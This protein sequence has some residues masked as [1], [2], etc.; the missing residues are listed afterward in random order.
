MLPADDR[1]KTKWAST[2]SPFLVLSAIFLPI[3]LQKVG[4]EGK[5]TYLGN[6]THYNLEHVRDWSNWGVYNNNNNMFLAAI[7]EQIS[8]Y[9][10]AV[11]Y[12]AD[13]PKTNFHYIFFFILRIDFF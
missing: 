3:Q 2:F 13:Q 8:F 5:N 1:Q 7:L 12:L 6:K 11:K 4:R 9:L 10:Q